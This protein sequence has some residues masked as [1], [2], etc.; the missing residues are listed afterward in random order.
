M[1]HSLQALAWCMAVGVVALIALPSSAEDGAPQ[2]KDLHIQQMPMT[3]LTPPIPDAGPSSSGLAVSATVDRPD[4][5]Y[6]DGDRL[7]L[8]VQT[9]E[10]AYV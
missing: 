10:D 1:S 8:T 3:E 9:T 6:R 5:S 4:R 2:L 7:V